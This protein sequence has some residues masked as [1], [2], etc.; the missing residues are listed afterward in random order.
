MSLVLGCFLSHAVGCVSSTVFLERNK[1]VPTA[2]NTSEAVT[3]FFPFFLEGKG[4]NC[5]NFQGLI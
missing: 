2:L 5:N 3:C 1:H 4:V